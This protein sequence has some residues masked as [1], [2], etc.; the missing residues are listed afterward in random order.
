MTI[1]TF[2]DHP[3][4]AQ[5][6]Q[7][8]ELQGRSEFANPAVA[9]NEQY[10]FARD[11]AHAITRLIQTQLDRTPAVLASTSALGNLSSHLQPPLNEL[12]AFVSNKNP[13]HIVNAATQLEQNVLPS[14]W[15]LPVLSEATAETNLPALLQQQAE[16]SAETIR[17]LVTAKE[18]LVEALAG[19]T[20]SAEA[21]RLRLE[22]MQESAAKE[23]AEA[24]AAVANLQKAY[25]EKEIERS[26]AF[27]QAVT[28]FKDTFT[29]V[30]TENAATA[31]QKLADL[32]D[33]RQ[34][35][36][37]IVQVVGN[38]GVTGNYQRI[39]NDESS[40]A[41]RWRWITIAIFSSGICVAAA[42]FVKFWDQPFSPENLWS[43]AVRLLYAIAITA[44]AWYTARES[45]RH[46][47]NADRA[48]QTELE[49]ASIGPFIELMP[50]EKKIEIK[51]ALTK[52]YFGRSVNDHQIQTPLDALQVKDLAIE[53]AKVFKK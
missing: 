53:L 43:V 47:S 48:R 6:A 14:L 22:G 31:A 35:A 30:Q 16:S 17:Q 46:R 25:A 7:L 38:I 2:R 49:L 36:A 41:N 19:E 37:K 9:D 27:E 52:I 26:A 40:Q 39:A 32:D 33:Q 15:G 44:P 42:T 20:A 13:G 12:N 10:A 4:R 21:L 28:G 11:K 51:E 34:R 23:R 3:I 45:A 29:K 50:E 1:A 18:Q 8:L 5:L 24:A